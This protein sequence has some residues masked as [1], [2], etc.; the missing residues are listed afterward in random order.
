MNILD[1]H[2]DLTFS[3]HF[4]AKKMLQKLSQYFFWKGLKSDVYKK[5][6]PCVTCTSVWGPGNHGRPPLVSIPVGGPL[7]CVWIDFVE[8]DVTEDSNRYSLVF[9]D[10]LTKWPEVHALSNRKAETVAWYLL[11]FIWK[12]GVSNKIIH[13]QAAEFLSEVLQET[14]ALVGLDQLRTS[15]GHPRLMAS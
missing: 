12:H 10:Y 7:D 4:A 15:R 14:V 11:D 9:Q 13:D 5:C 2:H 6:F 8:L 3:G 1:E